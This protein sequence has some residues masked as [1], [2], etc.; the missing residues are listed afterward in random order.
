MAIGCRI[1]RPITGWPVGGGVGGRPLWSGFLFAG[2]VGVDGGTDSG[3]EI[4]RALDAR[5]GVVENMGV[6]RGRS[7]VGVTQQFLDRSDVGSRLEAVIADG[8]FPARREKFPVPDYREFEA[9]ILETLGN[10]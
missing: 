10:L 9:T 6:E 2:L 7:D 8:D 1:L 3:E 4:W 5:A